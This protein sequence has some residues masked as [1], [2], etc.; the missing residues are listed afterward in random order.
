MRPGA[1]L[2]GLALL[3]P[4]VAPARAGLRAEVVE[5][6]EVTAETVRTATNTERDRSLTRRR[7]LDGIR[8]ITRSSVLEAMLCLRFGA[9]IRL[10]AD[11]GEE[12]PDELT[13]LLRHPTL[14]R[15]DGVSATEES[16]QTPVDGAIAYA[17]F[18]FDHP[19]EMRA[20]DW[21]L[22][23]MAGTQVL[24]TQPFHVSVPS[25]AASLCQGR[26]VS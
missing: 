24:A 22:V 10:T 15:P 11:A 21:T 12:L 23:F 6:G 1:A 14:T 4:G 16:F 26:P 17:G 5:A 3:L 2:L 13:T 7:L 8:F 9:T 25:P 19:W 18:T 20:G